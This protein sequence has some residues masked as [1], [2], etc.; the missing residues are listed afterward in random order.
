MPTR[1]TKAGASSRYGRNLS[2]RQCRRRRAVV[3]C[4]APLRLDT[5]FLEHLVDFDARLLERVGRGHALE[6]DLVQGARPDVAGPPTLGLGYPRDPRRFEVLGDD[7]QVAAAA[8]RP[9]DLMYARIFH[10][11][12]PRR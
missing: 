7:L 8:P 10:D 11:R 6:V 12:H 5:G 4:R 1:R 3:T 9:H 2:R